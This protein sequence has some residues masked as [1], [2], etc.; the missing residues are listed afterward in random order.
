MQIVPMHEKACAHTEF[1]GHRDRSRGGR[2]PNYGSRWIQLHVYLFVTVR[3]YPKKAPACQVAIRPGSEW[4]RTVLC[5]LHAKPGLPNFFQKATC[6]PIKETPCSCAKAWGGFS[7]NFQP[8]EHD[9]HTMCVCMQVLNAWLDF[10]PN[11]RFVLILYE[12]R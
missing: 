1:T 5:V 11:G 10:I 12:Y 3:V 4:G 2:N 9:T 6:C 7:L 8:S